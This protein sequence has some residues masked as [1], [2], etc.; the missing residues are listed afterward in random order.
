MLPFTCVRPQ[1]LTTNADTRALMSVLSSI[2]HVLSIE[3]HVSWKHT[4]V[5]HMRCSLP[6]PRACT[7]HGDTP[8]IGTARPI[9]AARLQWERAPQA[10]W[11]LAARNH[12]DASHSVYPRNRGDR[13]SGPRHRS[14]EKSSREGCSD[15]ARTAGALRPTSRSAGA[16]AAR[17]CRETRDQ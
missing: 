12:G 13:C 5:T 11:S 16:I 1:T 2:F 9:S 8:P 17:R 3:T 4:T 15:S 7:P 6:L 10:S 14:A